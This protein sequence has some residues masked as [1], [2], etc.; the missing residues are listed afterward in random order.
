MNILIL[1]PFYEYSHRVWAEGFQKHS[2]HNIKILSLSPHHWKWRMVGGAVELA[3]TYNK[4]VFESDLILATD[5]LDFNAF[6]SLAR[7]D[8]SKIS[9]AIYFHENQITYPWNNNEHE[10]QK[11]KNHHYGFI[12]FTSCLVA[13][14]IFFN[15]NFHKSEFLNALPDFLKIFPSFGYKK[16]VDS[17]I[18]KSKVLPIGLELGTNENNKEKS[19]I[20]CFLWNHRWEHDKNP[21]LFFHILFQLKKEHIP[22]ELIVLGKSYKRHPTIFEEARE[23]LKDEIIQFG[24]LESS[25]E[26]KNLV[27]RANILL[28]TS[29]QDFFGISIV[30]AIAAGLHPILPDRLAYPEHIHPE[31]RDLVFYQNDGQLL[32]F[33]KK[34]INNK[35]YTQDYEMAQFAQKY[36]W[37]HLIEQYDTILSELKKA[38]I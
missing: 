25:E 3:E 36:N 4:M 11:E 21:E 17:I 22:F 8:Q 2:F 12:N 27:N 32:N 31:H 29:H 28:V 19:A 6:L 13:E 20:P 18:G 15:S 7:I 23:H 30:E 14:R 9:T 38:Y 16:H 1:D 35:I 33:V 34:I 10:G 24:Y 37:R 5:M 26:Y